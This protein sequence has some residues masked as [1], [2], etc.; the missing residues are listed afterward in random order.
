MLLVIGFL[1]P[2][3]PQWHDILWMY[4]HIFFLILPIILRILPSA[5][6]SNSRTAS[7]PATLDL[8]EKCLTRVHLL[9]FVRGSIMR[10]AGL[11][12]SAG[13]WWE[14]ERK[15]GE[16]VRK[17]EG[18]QRMAERLGFGYRDGTGTQN[19]GGGIVGEGKLKRNAK[20]AVEALKSGFQPAGVL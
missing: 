15:E 8:L 3:V 12:A 11:R 20:V 4:R 18:V 16:W 9:K 1:T 13:D 6:P 14:Q 5:P 17:D 10:D 19:D 2:C 7:I